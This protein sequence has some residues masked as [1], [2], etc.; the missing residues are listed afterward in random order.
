MRNDHRNNEKKERPFIPR[1]EMNNETLWMQFLTFLSAREFITSF[2]L[3]DQVFLSR[4]ENFT[5]DYLSRI[6]EDF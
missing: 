1:E 4:L 2:L 6:L 3:V 5:K